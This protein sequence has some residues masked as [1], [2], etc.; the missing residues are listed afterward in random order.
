MSII[1]ASVNN[2]VAV[3]IAMFAVIF[4][5]IFAAF[6]LTR[7]FFPE[8]DVGLVIVRTPYPGATPREVEK[9][10]ITRIESAIEG[11]NDID[12][13]ESQA[14]ENAGIVIIEVE[15]GADADE[16]A[17]EVR[18][19][20]D[21]I[22]DFPGQVEE[23][24][25][26]V[27]EP[28]QPVIS[29]VVYGDARELRLKRVADEVK[30]ELLAS[31]IVSE[32]VVSGT[33]PEEISIELE[34]ERLEAYGLTFREVGLAV[35]G[36]NIDLAGGEIEAP[37][38]KIL[39]RTLGEETSGLPLEEILVRSTLEGSSIRLGDLGTVKDTFDDTAVRG[40]YKNKRAMQVTVFKRGNEDAVEISQYVKDYL[41]DK[42]AQYASATP[43][44]ESGIQFDYRLDLARFIRQRISLLTKNALQGLALVFIAL[45]LFMNFRLAFW[46]GAGLAV[47]FL[48]TFV[49]MMAVGA[50]INMISL[51][52][53]II[54]IGIIVDDAIVVAENIYARMENDMP[55]HMAAVEGAEEVAKPVFATVLTTIVAF[56]P[57][58]FIQSVVGDFLRVLPLV[59]IAA[60]VL[61]LIE[62]FSF[63]PSHLAEFGST[64]RKEI[65]RGGL[66]GRIRKAFRRANDWKNDLINRRL[67]NAYVALLKVS[68]AWRYVTLAVAAFISMAMGS[69][70]VAGMLP[71][72]FF[73]DVDAETIIADVEMATGTKEERTQEVLEKIAGV[74]QS[75]PEVDSTYAVIGMKE[76]EPV[77]AFSDPAVIGQVIVDLVGAEKRD[78]S[79]QQILDA[80]REEV[81]R[82][83]GATKLKFEERS[84]GPAG[85]DIALQIS[86]P[87]LADAQEATRRIKNLLDEFVGVEDIEDDSG[88][89]KLEMRIRL[90]QTARA[91]GIDEASLARQ[92][93]GAFFGY[94]AQ[95]LQRGEE[96]VKV[97]VRLDQES[98]ASI[99]ELL[100]LRIATPAGERVPLG[101]IA[102]LELTRGITQITRVNGLRTITV[103]ASVDS[104]QAN[105]SEVTTAME[106]EFDNIRSEIPTVQFSFEGQKQDTRENI[107]A[108]AVYFPVALILIYCILA[109][110]F[111]SYIQ[112]LVVMVAIPYAIIGA[113]LGHLLFG[114]IPGRE[115]W[116]ITFL[117]LIGMVG[118]SGIV[119]NDSLILVSFI[120]NERRRHPGQLLAAVVH[121]GRR[122]LRPILLT[123]ITTVLGLFPIMMETSFQAQFLIPMAISISFGLLLAT[124][125]TLLLLPCIYMVF[126]DL[127]TLVHWLV[128]GQWETVTLKPTG[129]LEQEEQMQA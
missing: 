51:F 34:P 100:R 105:A 81:G 91:L 47:A 56:A 29:V 109:V 71:F 68:I 28:R 112:P 33:R 17:D 125:L 122:R 116:P 69:L 113:S 78:R 35:A 84:G 31:N 43:N 104:D 93:R 110:L 83:P 11:V 44:A 15:T 127:R 37:I 32:V 60:L 9:G 58:A 80:W 79:S 102:D 123:S 3:N 89:G 21:R 39:I 95:N 96:E 88:A 124:G 23:T 99:G 18:N 85:P 120:N 16:V 77:Q 4:F 2:P 27:V 70:V 86:A 129:Y 90:R 87:A 13:V 45:V 65:K 10:V 46:V 108:L 53:L 66:Y 64:K 73:P 114:L 30:D 107:G 5:G 48:G 75:F 24:I 62:V 49:F 97:Y 20:V 92:V 61:S 72:V 55:P 59:V 82:I 98:R 106:Q 94:E 67:S 26:E 42:R 117:S 22:D 50:T 101:E 74:A 63:M 57:L 76:E 8:T 52:G 119:V 41:E 1:R 111:K 6:N 12:E 54:V 128:T 14:L 103:Q 7:E 121:A 115:A 19:E 25:V 38:G 126:E 40:T 118:L 36:N